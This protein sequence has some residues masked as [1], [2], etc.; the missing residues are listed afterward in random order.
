MRMSQA[1]F[2][3]AVRAAAN[4]LGTPNKCT[5]RLVQKWEMGDHVTCS[6]AYLVALRAVTGLPARDLGFQ[7]PADYSE[8][9]ASIDVPEQ[10]DTPGATG[11]AVPGFAHYNTEA[12]I[13]GSMDR[14]SR[15]LD[16][17]ATATSRTTDFVE[18]TT[19]RLFDLEHHSAARLLAP[20]VERHLSMVTALLTAARAEAVRH[21]LTSSCGYCTL[22]AGWIA[23]DRGNTPASHKFW[24]AT[25]G[26]AA[27][28]EDY[29]L[30]AAVLI[31]QSY[32][33]ARSGDP[34]AAWQ[35]A[36]T[37]AA[38]TPDDARATAWATGRAALYA[39][40]LG[41]RKA[42]E[43]ALR[44]TLDLG[45]D[46]TSPTPG[47]DGQP[48]TRSFDRAQLLSSAAHTA[49]LLGDPNAIDYATRAVEA[50][51]PAKVKSRAVVFAEAALTA[52]LTGEFALCLDYGTA[53]ATLAHD[54]EV[55]VA[56]ALLQQVVPIVLPHADR[57]PIRLL[58]P[59]LADPRGADPRGAD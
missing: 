49:A 55:S 13:D 39:M 22:L 5:K 27:E 40:Q 20:T 37:A 46:L 16:N 12:M 42:A 45:I 32:A 29:G 43:T 23:F 52:A 6:P 51:S 8:T 35:L 17:P 50:L 41:E 56:A 11:S 26:A 25:T 54:L 38:H 7:L 30:F 1:E 15:T 14:L 31:Y 4:A 58:L 24:A 44:R 2:A 57:Q 19:A 10:E 3:L 33:A 18:T 59:R 34:A 48:G 9:G 36:H 21:R 47:D 53:A 28:T